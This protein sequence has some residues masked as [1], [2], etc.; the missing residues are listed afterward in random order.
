MDKLRR[1]LSNASDPEQRGIVDE[2]WDS[3]TLSWESRIKGFVG[4]FVLGTLLS[5][6]GTCLLWI[7]GHGLTVFAIFYTVGNLISLASTCF[8]MGPWKQLKKMFAETRWI[9]TLV[10]IAMFV[11][12]LMAALWWKNFALA[13][14]F[15][16]LQFMAMT[17]YSLS[18]IPYA[19][20]AA[21]GCFSTCIA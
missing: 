1:H 6:V 12:T 3:T 5:I 11:L 16:V 10:M 18:Y 13:I 14:V 15:C 7:P 20:D 9:A 4:C 19:R 17:W 8:L 2:L 21:K